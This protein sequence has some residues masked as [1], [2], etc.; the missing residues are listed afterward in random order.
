MKNLRQDK[1]LELIE[2]YD[3]ETQE[4]L[5][6]KL[7]ESGFTVT[8][9]TVSRDIRALKLV[10][11]ASAAGGY[12]YVRPTMTAANQP[13]FGAAISESIVK[14]DSAGNLIVIKTYPGLAQ[15]VAAY[16]DSMPSADILGCVAGDDTI[17]VCVRNPEHI[18]GV[19]ESI[20]KLLKNT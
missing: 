20:K 1:I 19:C 12:K 18:L 15:P 17:M 3:I 11:G 5:A 4:E 10:K 8:Q 9:A 13:R 6:D 2:K 14:M 16:I 7:T